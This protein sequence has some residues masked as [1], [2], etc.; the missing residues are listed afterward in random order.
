MNAD[1]INELVSILEA[2]RKDDVVCPNPNEWMFFYK[3][4]CNGYAERKKNPDYGNYRPLVLSGW[5]NNEDNQAFNF[6]NSIV[7]F[8]ITYLEK[9]SAIKDFLTSNQKWKKGYANSEY[10]YRQSMYGYKE[11]M[12]FLIES[13][14]KA[15]NDK[16]Q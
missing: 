9:R 15:I 4:I 11:S 14:L 3:E 16:N 10:A 12:M 6:Y 13:H 8:F 5:H 1:E 7:Y 2:L